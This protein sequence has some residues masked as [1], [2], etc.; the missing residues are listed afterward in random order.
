MNDDSSLSNINNAD[1]HARMHLYHVLEQL[2]KYFTPT[3]ITCAKSDKDIYIL[4]GITTFGYTIFLFTSIGKVLD[5]F[6]QYFS[7]FPIFTHI[8]EID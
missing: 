1:G 6:Y 8:Y 2:S 4:A 7:P 3:G 5:F